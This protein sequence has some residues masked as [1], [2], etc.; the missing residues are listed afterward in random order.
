VLF[1][2][3]VLL[4]KG[5]GSTPGSSPREG[6]PEKC[7]QNR[8][9]VGIAT[10]VLLVKDMSAGMTVHEAADKCGVKTKT[11]YVIWKERDSL[12]SYLEDSRHFAARKRLTTGRYPVLAPAVSTFANRIREVRLPFSFGLLQAECKKQAVA[13]GMTGFLASAGCVCRWLKRGGFG[14]FVRLHGEVGSVDQDLMAEEMER[15]RSKLS[16]FHPDNI[17]NEDESG[18]TYQCLRSVSVLWK[19]N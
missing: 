5:S 14:G 16:P 6:F 9:Q 12:L 8:E 10:K 11:A 7:K 13:V 19:L 3:H 1:F 4:S 15:V 2:S 18:F 17:Y